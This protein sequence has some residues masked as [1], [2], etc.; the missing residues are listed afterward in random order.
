MSQTNTGAAA[1]GAAA[2]TT[3]AAAQPVAASIDE[4]SAA[5]PD[6]KAFAFECL[7]GK[8]TLTESHAAY[9]KL[10]KT[11]LDEANTKLAA[12]PAETQEATETNVRKPGVKPVQNATGTT[13]TV[14]H[15]GGDAIEAFGTAVEE[16]MAKPGNMSRKRAILAV[17]HKDPELHRSYLEATN[18][19]PDSRAMIAKRFR[20]AS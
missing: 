12:K 8:K 13:T 20:Q 10:M 19:D 1:T 4:L 5:F 6:E 16:Q 17:A 9:S 7:S 15:D 18:S 2:S 14:T 3:A 11:R